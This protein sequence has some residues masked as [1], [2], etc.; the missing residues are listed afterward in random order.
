[1]EKLETEA[2]SCQMCRFV[3]LLPR[4]Q[5]NANTEAFVFSLRQKG[6]LLLLSNISLFMHRLAETVE[7]AYTLSGYMETSYII[8]HNQLPFSIYMWRN[9]SDFVLN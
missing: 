8:Q 3:R 6:T 7:P 5:D 1:M 9:Q 4:Q 2:K